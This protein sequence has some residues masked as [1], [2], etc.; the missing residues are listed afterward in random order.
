MLIRV[1]GTML[2]LQTIPKSQLLKIEVFFFIKVI[3]PLWS[4]VMGE[5]VS[6]QN[7]YVETL[8]PITSKCELTGK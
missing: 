3:Y 6:L 7:S 4:T 8:I 5:I 2:M 1:S